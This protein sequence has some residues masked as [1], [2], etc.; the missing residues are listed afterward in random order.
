[1]SDI[2][3]ITM[4]PHNYEICTQRA[5]ECLIAQVTGTE[6]CYVAKPIVSFDGPMTSGNNC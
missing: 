3:L 4:G 5:R 2:E 6:S 1:M